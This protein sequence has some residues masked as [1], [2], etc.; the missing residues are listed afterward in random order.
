M[1]TKKL[2]QLYLDGQLDDADRQRA[3]EIFKNDPAARAELKEYQKIGQ[4]MKE[5]AVPS[6]DISQADFMW[7][8][9]KSAI[10]RGEISEDEADSGERTPWWNWD[11]R[12]AF[13]GVA[14][15]VMLALGMV[16]WAQQDRIVAVQD[17]RKE[18]YSTVTV[19]TFDPSVYPAEYRS[20]HAGANV[21]WLTGADAYGPPQGS[22]K[23]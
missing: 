10:Q 23:S 9:V 18:G 13:A 7:S 6:G 3:E 21:I 11:Y 14:A 15:G 5:V 1:S 17:P 22:E 8:R 19:Y 12:W 4:V 20:T 16:F 2:I